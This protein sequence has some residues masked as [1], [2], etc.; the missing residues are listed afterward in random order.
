MP[1]QLKP[2]EIISRYRFVLSAFGLEHVKAQLYKP[3]KELKARESDSSFTTTGTDKGEPNMHS[4]FSL[5]RSPIRTG[6]QPISPLGTPVF[7]DVILYKQDQYEERG[8][9]LTM[10]L[11]EVEQSKNI[12]KTTIQGRNGTVKEYISDGDYIISLKGAISRTFK[13][14]YPK[15]EM[16]QFL[17]LLKQNKALKVTSEYLLMFGVY[18]L[19]VDSY[20]F[21]QE[22]GRVNMQKFEINCSSDMPLLLKKKNV[23]S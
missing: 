19:V 17:E 2:A 13:S 7:S 11:V 5:G 12:V 9:Q 3:G 22:S 8:L 10:C 6:Q 4:G 21:G 18:E 1:E 23:Q 16:I 14:N 20:K 15:E